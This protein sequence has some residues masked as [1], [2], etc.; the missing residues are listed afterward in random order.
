[1]ISRKGYY[2]NIDILFNIVHQQRY[3]ETFFLPY[4]YDE[5]GKRKSNQPI[6]WLMANYTEMLK[7]HWETFEFFE[8]D[9]NMYHSIATYK[10]FP[11]FSY[12]WRIKAQQQ[13]IWMKEFKNHIVEYD[14]FIETDS[15]NLNESYVDALNIKTFFDKYKAKY[16][17][18][19]SG[20]KGFHFV[21]P[22]KEFDWL[23][24]DVYNEEIEAKIKNFSK[25][26][27]KLPVSTEEGKK[28]FDKVTL[29]KAIALRMKT[30]LVCPTIDTTIQDIKRVK[31]T[32]YT[33]DVKSGYIAYP[34]NDE[35]LEN[36]N[37]EEYTAINV[38]RKKNHR[39]GLLLRN[40]IYMV[41]RAHLMKKMLIDLGILKDKI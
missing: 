9:M 8:K 17:V 15:K 40:T 41:E 33:Y 20:S 21:I 1:M 4:S 19:F 23:G 26:L 27:L 5:K 39:R 3:R 2:N 12:N 34:L 22:A 24:W 31:K 35:Q 38:L 18:N 16:Y 36:F 25:F 30:L 7:K 11:M 32:A 37:K 6:R 28:I 29:F 10:D 13:E 14:L